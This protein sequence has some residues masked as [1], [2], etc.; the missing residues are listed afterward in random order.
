MDLAEVNTLLSEGE[1]VFLNKHFQ[2]SSI[3]RRKNPEPE[4]E[5]RR[6]IVREFFD[7]IGIRIY[8]KQVHV[9][10]DAILPKYSSG[11]YAQY[12]DLKLFNF[13]NYLKTYWPTIE[14]EVKN[15][16][17]SSDIFREIKQTILLKAYKYE[18]GERIERYMSPK[19]IYFPR[20]YSN[21]ENMDKLFEDIPEI[22]FLHPYYL[23]REKTLRKKKRRGRK[24][25]EY[26]WKKFAEILGV[27]SS[28]IVEKND[29]WLSIAGKQGYEWISKQYS[30]SGMHEIRGDSVSKDIQ[31]LIEYCAKIE[32]SEIVRK[33]MEML[34]H[35]LSENWKLY[36]EHCKTIYKYKY[37]Y[38]I[39]VDYDNSSFLQ[40][41]KDAKWV[42]TEHG[43]FS[44]PTEIFLGTERNKLLIGD[45]FK[46]T[47]LSGSNIFLDD[48]GI[49][50]QPNIQTVINHIKEYKEAN[51]I[52]TK[53]EVQKFET[54][55]LYISEKIESLPE[56]EQDKIKEIVKTFEKDELLYIPRKDKSM[57]N[58]KHVFWKDHL[59]T[60]G[61]LRGYIENKGH[62]IY[63]KELKTFL[64]KLGVNENPSIKQALGVLEQLKEQND[65]QKI[66]I[67]ISKIYLYIND[68]IIHDST[69]NFKW[70]NYTFL[71]RN[72]N[73]LP[74]N[75]I[76]FEDDEDFAKE[77]YDKVEFVF[78]QHTSW[79]NLY[80]FFRRAGFKSFK[81]NLQINK[82]IGELRE[83]EGGETAAII[84]A[85]ELAQKYLLHNN[86]EAYDMLKSEID[87]EILH[88]LEIYETTFLKLDLVLKQN[89]QLPI[90]SNGIIKEAY[91]STEE[92]RL[93]T[94]EGIALH[95]GYVA[96]ELSRIFGSSAKDLFPFLNSMLPIIDQDDELEKQLSLFGIASD[97]E[98]YKGPESIEFLTEEEKHETNNVDPSV[99]S[100]KEFEKTDKD[101]KPAVKPPK[102]QKGLIDP[103]E[104]FPI[105]VTELIPYKSSEGESQK[106][107]REI[108]LRK[109]K[110]SA[111]IPFKGPQKETIPSNPE[112][113]ALQIVINYEQSE[114]RE[115]EDR[116][117]QRGIGYDIYSITS[118][119][120]ERFIEVKHFSDK[121]GRFQ[122]L[123][124]QI[125]KGEQE[126]ERYYV[127]IIKGL[128]KDTMPELFIIQ[129][130]LKWLTPEPPIRK[131]Y[132]HW[133]TAVK[134]KIEFAKA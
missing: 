113:I 82:H 88:D 119:G 99:K 7:G 47:N 84:K 12:D 44:K 118:G 86:I 114:G 100:A 79:I 19:E 46:Y 33:K 72:G 42:P 50:I 11:K 30:P 66:K 8:F 103:N 40:Y 6:E 70:E 80:Y 77:L 111:E 125:K 5:Q 32:D 58:P 52:I 62:A 89:S 73:F 64:S 106:V 14:S 97:I 112:E 63:N 128:R 127:Y 35:S 92:N 102:P 121:E 38:E 101:G 39:S 93:Y 24:R 87:P 36:K 23:N 28:P 68:L 132:S 29:A 45:K 26:G 4:E 65:L 61:S 120:Q 20:R 110:P 67:Y 10:K 51:F 94:L 130:P 126:G 27:W 48:L 96:K 133:K 37:H 104:F 16:K 21:T 115:A 18:N 98:N 91:Y 22:Y 124:H 117:S 69:N 134:E 13:A 131:E 122:L 31:K 9:I 109:G 34:W 76:Y 2:I 53:S 17:I 108:D 60:F 116:H 85:L 25:T 129:N 15:K 55:Y 1:L 75:Q 57:W 83:I 107:A 54:I 90:Q 123:P 49:K 95:S 59:K 81:Q 3:S 43:L 74:A 41:L 105:K 71:T 56:N 78:T